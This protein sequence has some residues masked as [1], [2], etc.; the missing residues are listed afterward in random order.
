MG[1][2]RR[3]REEANPH[4]SDFGASRFVYSERW[5]YEPDEM[6]RRRERAPEA[7]YEAMR[8]SKAPYLLDD[9]GLRLVPW[10]GLEGHSAFR[11]GA[12]AAFFDVLDLPGLGPPR[13]ITDSSPDTTYCFATYLASVSSLLRGR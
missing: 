9:R 4:G 11:S 12:A 8:V 7:V 1:L 2:M 5:E 13:A 10:G 3:G 6:D